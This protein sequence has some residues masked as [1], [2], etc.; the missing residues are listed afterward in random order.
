MFSHMHSVMRIVI[1]GLFVW[2]KAVLPLGGLQF[3]FYS[4]R[5]PR[6]MNNCRVNKMTLSEKNQQD[7][8]R[9]SKV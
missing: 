9:L 2:I 3:A 5:V 8:K 7:H 1:F 6:I 4:V